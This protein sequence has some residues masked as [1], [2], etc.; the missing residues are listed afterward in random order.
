[1]INAGAV[2][3]SA[4]AKRRREQQNN[5]KVPHIDYYTGFCIK[6]QQGFFRKTIGYIYTV[7]IDTLDY[8]KTEDYTKKKVWYHEN[9][10]ELCF[11][12]CKALNTKYH[13]TGITFNVD[14]VEIK[15]YITYDE[16]GKEHIQVV[17]WWEG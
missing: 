16:T 11:T 9:D 12:V 10:R 17:H 4:A 13:G 5:V 15:E 7:N 1:M 3:A 6:V 14:S 2:A 8:K